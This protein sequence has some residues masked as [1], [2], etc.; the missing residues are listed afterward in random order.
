MSDNSN[1]TTTSASALMANA[2]V[3]PKTQ[4]Q[5]NA[6]TCTWYAGGQCYMPRNCYDCI[7]VA[8]PKTKVRASL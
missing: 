4:P 7:N 1:S 5:N 6:D 2:T 8:L 3:A